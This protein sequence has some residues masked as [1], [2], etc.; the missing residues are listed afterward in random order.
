VVTQ[1][2]EATITTTITEEVEI[3]VGTGQLLTKIISEKANSK[4]R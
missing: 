1:V 2:R 4:I 3:P